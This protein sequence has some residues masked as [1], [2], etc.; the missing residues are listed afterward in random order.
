[1]GTPFAQFGNVRLTNGWSLTYTGG[2]EPSVFTIRT[3]PHLDHLESH[4]SLTFGED[5]VGYLSLRD[6][7]LERPYLN[8]DRTWDLPILDRRWKWR[9]GEISG[10]YNVRRPDKTYKREK[11]PQELAALCLEAM[12]E[13]R[14]R[15]D[16]SRLPN[17]ARPEILWK[18]D[19]P[20]SMLDEL[21]S[22]LGCT[23]TLDYFSDQ[24][25]IWPLGEGVDL[26]EGP[27]IR[28]S[29]GRDVRAIPDSIKATARRCSIRRGSR[30]KPWAATSMASG[31]NCP[32]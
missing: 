20:A 6:C 31:R 9:F 30:P 27:T 16:V 2:P 25:V 29:E 3:V 28:R 32:N 24:V 23:W 8:D 1:M 18:V 26:P 17:F 7:L 19:N 10:S 4:S 14:D 21:V 22:Q 12:G 5:G 11:T 15:W 13:Q